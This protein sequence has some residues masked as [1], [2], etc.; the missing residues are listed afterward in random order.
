MTTITSKIAKIVE[1]TCKSKSNFFG[2][3]AWTNH[4]QNVV[5]FA[6]QL[7]E[8]MQADVEVVE[9]AALLHDYASV[10]DKKLYPEHHIHGARL[11]RELLEKYNYPPEKISKIENAILSHRGS[12]DIKR[13]AIESEILAS[14][15]AMA[16]FTNLESLFYLAFV[17]KG[18][19]IEEGREFVMGKLNRSWNKLLPEAKEI[20]A[21]FY[22][23]AEKLF[24]RE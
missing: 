5:I 21:P 3:S 24:G 1:E 9:L 20:I 18:M 15:D 11:A 8:K 19:K 12:K 2:Y 16:H 14:A 7:A 4:I 17:T 23:G 22:E 6:K 13:Q 10:L